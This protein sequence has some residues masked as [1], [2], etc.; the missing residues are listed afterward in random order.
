MDLCSCS[1]PSG[2]PRPEPSALRPRECVF[3]AAGLGL[4]V[5]YATQMIPRADAVP[6][7]RVIRQILT[8]VPNWLWRRITA[9]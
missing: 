4:L 5:Q 9:G 2:R 7:R 8:D 3:L 1:K 6:W